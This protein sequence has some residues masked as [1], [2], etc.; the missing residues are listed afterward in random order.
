MLTFIV[1]QDK[2]IANNSVNMN[3]SAAPLS[4]KWDTVAVTNRIICSRRNRR[5]DK[6]TSNTVK[7]NIFFKTYILTK[8]QKI[9]NFMPGS[10]TD[11]STTLEPCKMRKGLYWQVTQNVVSHLAFLRKSAWVRPAEERK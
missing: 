6:G 2:N 8:F 11:K 10:I 4:D 1:K 7:Y 9:S 3:V 5:G